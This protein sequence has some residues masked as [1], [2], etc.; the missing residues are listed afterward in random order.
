MASLLLRLVFKGEC[1]P[2]KVAYI[3][4]NDNGPLLV[5]ASGH[6]EKQKQI[7]QTSIFNKFFEVQSRFL[8]NLTMCPEKPRGCFIALINTS[9]G[10]NELL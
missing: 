7:C 6:P 10:T 3:F 1:R 8:K 2:F 4:T 5:F 9:N